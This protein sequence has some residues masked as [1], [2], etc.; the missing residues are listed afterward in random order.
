MN[1]LIIEDEALAARQLQGMIRAY[2]PAA[3]LLGTLDSV[4]GAVAWFTHHPTP[5]LLFADI[6]LV[7]G[8]SFEVFERVQVRCPVIFTTA[9]DEFALRAFRVN[10]VDYLLKPIDEAALRRALDKFGDLRRLYGQPAPPVDWRELVTALR[11][12]GPAAQPEYAERFL[13]RQG[14]RLMPVEVGEIAYFFSE[15]RMSFVKTWDGRSL[16]VDYTLDELAQRLNPRQFFRA[17]RQ[18]ILH[19]KAVDRVHLHFN[20]RLKLELKPAVSEEVFISR[21]RA[22]EFRAWMGE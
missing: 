18:F 3:N 7:D 15:E 20:G 1:I 4:E 8:Q 14:S 22:G 12:P 17:N 5:D 11:A 6:E 21:E 9:Y 10:S 13:L 16:V 2:D 19:A